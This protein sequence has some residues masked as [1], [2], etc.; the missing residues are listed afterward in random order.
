MAKPWENV[1]AWASYLSNRQLSG[2][3]GHIHVSLRNKDGRN[4]FGLSKEETAAGG[5]K[6]A[7]WKDLQY[8]SQEAE[9]FLA[10]LLEGLKDGKLILWRI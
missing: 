5:R 7:K 6:D 3:S 1:G 8:I 9:W 4:I 10:G 2:C